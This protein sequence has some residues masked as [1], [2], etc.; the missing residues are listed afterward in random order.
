MLNHASHDHPAT[1]AARAACRKALAKSQATTKRDRLIM[2]MGQDYCPTPN[3]WLFYAARRFAGYMD[4]DINLAAEAV[5]A[6]FAPSGDKA[7]D[8]RRL[9][10]GYM[11]TEDPYTIRSITLRCA[12]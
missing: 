1:S 2:V 4:S 10:N 7:A 9:Q 12:S 6:H 8:A 3:H 11:I 5:L